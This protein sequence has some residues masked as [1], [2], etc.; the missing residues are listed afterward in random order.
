LEAG[1][2]V[3]LNGALVGASS[4]PRGRAYRWLDR[5]APRR[6]RLRYWIEEKLLKGA[7]QWY[8]PIGVA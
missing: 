3:K 2:R 6:G 4:V 7:P 8:G 5:W 1:L